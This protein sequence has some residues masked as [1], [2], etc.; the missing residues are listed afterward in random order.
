MLYFSFEYLTCWSIL[1]RK[2]KENMRISYC[3]QNSNI[4]YA[5]EQ[6]LQLTSKSVMSTSSNHFRL[7]LERKFYQTQCYICYKFYQQFFSILTTTNN[8]I[9][10]KQK[11]SA[12][13]INKAFGKLTES[14]GRISTDMASLLKMPFTAI[15][16]HT[17]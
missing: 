15:Y 11:I 13:E 12:F 16:I 1:L 4:M 3:S 14:S 9:W 6:R 10:L 2:Q 17:Y 7:T 8:S 5:F